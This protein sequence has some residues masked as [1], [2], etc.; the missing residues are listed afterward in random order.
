[1]TSKERHLRCLSASVNAFK[2]N[3]GTSFRTSTGVSDHGAVHCC[4]FLLA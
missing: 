2:E 3:E 4:L 1:M